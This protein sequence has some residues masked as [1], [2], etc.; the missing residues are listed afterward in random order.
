MHRILFEFLSAFG[1]RMNFERSW[2]AGWALG[3]ILWRAIPER[4]ESSIRRVAMHLAK[5]PKQAAAIARQSFVSSARSFLELFLNRRLDERFFEERLTVG[6]EEIVRSV[7]ES[8]RPIVGATAHMGSWELLVG[9]LSRYGAGR[10]L[11]VV[12]R[13]QRNDDFNMMIHRLRAR[14]GVE[15]VPNRMAAR[16]VLGCLRKGGISAFLVDHNCSR[17]K[18]VF[19]PFLG[20]IAAVNMG[21]ALLAVRA[22]ALV[23]PVFLLRTGKGTYEFACSNPLDT[24]TLEGTPRERM[25]ETARF[26]TRAVGEQVR[27]NPEQWF[28]MHNRWKTQPAPLAIPQEPTQGI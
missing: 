1:Q 22:E 23:W 19:L 20:R 4:R 12:V 10:R 15:I 5:P 6:N 2:N 13:K 21:P 27:R 14:P 9:L 25:E 3:N 26:Y 7:I 24:A 11:Q 16:K 28:W 18:A 8:G 17:D